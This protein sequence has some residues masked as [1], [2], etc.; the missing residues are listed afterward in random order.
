MTQDIV[1]AFLDVHYSFRACLPITYGYRQ[2]EA[3]LSNHALRPHVSRM[4]LRDTRAGI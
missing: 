3:C 2:A 4:V 1:Y